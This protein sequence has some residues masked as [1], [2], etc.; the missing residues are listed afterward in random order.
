MATAATTQGLLAPLTGHQQRCRQ[1]ADDL[2]QTEGE[3]GD[4]QGSVEGRTVPM[5]CR[6]RLVLQ[7]GDH[8]GQD[9]QQQRQAPE[10]ARQQLGEEL[11]AD[12]VEGSAGGQVVRKQEVH[13]GEDEEDHPPAKA[14]S[15]V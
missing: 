6:R 1:E 10:D 15:S 14:D 2:P 13:A 7:P 5:L 4:G 12:L 8:D 11:G 3:E 9:N